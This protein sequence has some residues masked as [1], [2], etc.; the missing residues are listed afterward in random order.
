MGHRFFA[1]TA[2]ALTAVVILCAQTPAS[3][4]TA[5]AGTKAVKTT[6]PTNKP[7]A[8]P[9]TADSHPDL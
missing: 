7:W 1:S 9:R 4:Q 8:P 2:A 5:P 6:V 3:R